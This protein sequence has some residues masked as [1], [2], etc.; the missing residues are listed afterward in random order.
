MGTNKT[1]IGKLE[2]LKR[3]TFKFELNTNKEYDCYS[4]F[5]KREIMQIIRQTS[6]EL[7]FV[8]TVFRSE[9]VKNDIDKF[10]YIFSFLNSEVS[11][12]R[13][14]VW[15]LICG[16]LN[17]LQEN[18]NFSLIIEF[19]TL[20]FDDFDE[21]YSND[22]SIDSSQRKQAILNYGYDLLFK[23]EYNF[24]CDPEKKILFKSIIR[25]SSSGLHFGE[26][27]LK[28][29]QVINI[30]LSISY[31]I[32]SDKLGCYGRKVESPIYLPDPS[33]IFTIGKVYEGELDC[34]PDIAKFISNYFQKYAS[35]IPYLIDYLDKLKR[36][37]LVLELQELIQTKELFKNLIGK[38]PNSKDILIVEQNYEDA[39]L[40]L[41]AF[42]NVH[43]DIALSDE[44]VE[45]KA[46]KDYKEIVDLFK[47]LKTC[48]ELASSIVPI[49]L[50]GVGLK[51]CEGTNSISRPTVSPKL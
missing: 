16:I 6:W 4:D 13:D 12:K 49:D 43:P 41:K 42:C 47:S 27:L 7:P 18:I 15:N 20:F 9:S 30:N 39:N 17:N 50:E 45:I 8:R 22:N 24:L 40:R 3:E 38:Y 34:Y 32:S 21:V 28:L 37:A 29:Y 2:A 10:I 1:K 11:E 31:L 14:F 25:S 36:K 44:Q 33:S 35:E 23:K 46:I 48:V 26:M 5:Q 51:V 19:L